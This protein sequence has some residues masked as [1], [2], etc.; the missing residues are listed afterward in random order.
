[1]GAQ[2]GVARW[3]LERERDKEQ[4]QEHK[5]KG[6]WY[7][8]EGPSVFTSAPLSALPTRPMPQVQP[9]SLQPAPLSLDLW[10][11]GIAAVGHPWMALPLLAANIPDNFLSMPPHGN[12]TA[13]SHLSLSS[14]SF[15]PSLLPC[16]TDFS[17]LQYPAIRH[18]EQNAHH[19]SH[20]E[21]IFGSA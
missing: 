7:Q 8:T 10:T 19:T 2:D 5:N 15:P 3:P 9:T 13:G 17:T 20:I 11:A 12:D 6:Q 14:T 21:G 18:G 1:M 4:E 16:A